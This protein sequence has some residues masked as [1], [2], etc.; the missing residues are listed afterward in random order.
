MMNCLQISCKTNNLQKVRG[1]VEEVLAKYGVS[2][3]NTNL[4][5]LAVDELCANLI[6]HSHHCNQD[7]ALEVRIIKQ[8]ERFVFEICDK[9]DECFNIIDYQTPDIQ[10]I[11]SE[12][13]NGGMG[14]ILVKKIMDDIEIERIGTYNIRRLYKALPTQA[15]R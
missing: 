12:K 11:I 9:A 3:E 6:I 4:L 2:P 10:D 7:D 13:R 15:S 14:L 5:V 1:F 8:K